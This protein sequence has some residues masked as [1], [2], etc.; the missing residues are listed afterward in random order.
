VPPLSMRETRE[1][2]VRPISKAAPVAVVSTPTPAPPSEPALALAPTPTPNPEAA[3]LARL[4]Q[5]A[6][7]WHAVGGH[8]A[9]L[10]LFRL[11]L[12][13]RPNPPSGL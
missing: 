2:N 12:V 6:G 13:S 3:E 8:F 4:R 1:V 5:K 10:T 11:G 7:S 9:K